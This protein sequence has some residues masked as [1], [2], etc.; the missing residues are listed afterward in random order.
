MHEEQHNDHLKDL[1]AGDIQD[2]DERSPLTFGP[3]QGFVDAVNQPAEEAL[4][5]RLGEGLNGEISLE[6]KNKQNKERYEWSHRNLLVEA[7]R[8]LKDSLM[9][10]VYLLFGLRFLDI[11]SSHFDSGAEDSSGELH[12]IHSK[13]VTKLLRRWMGQVTGNT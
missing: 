5:G 2:A 13:Q 3:V 6:E 9:R 11:V 8:A 12:D 7:Q 10:V 4:V 1:K